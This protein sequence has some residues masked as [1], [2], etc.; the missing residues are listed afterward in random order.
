MNGEL[1]DWVDARVHVDVERLARSAELIGM[2][3]PFGADELCA[4]DAIRAGRTGSPT[5]PDPYPHPE[6]PFARFALATRGRL[7]ECTIRN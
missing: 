2:E 4:A 7:R 6:R 1:V 5:C 3:L